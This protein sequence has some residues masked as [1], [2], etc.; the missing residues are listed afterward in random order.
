M[1]GKQKKG[2]AFPLQFTYKGVVSALHAS[3][4]GSKPLMV[5]LPKGGKKVYIFL[6]I[7][8]NRHKKRPLVWRAL[9]RLCIE[10]RCKGG[11]CF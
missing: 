6:M 7:Q 11:K 9:S 8:T 1:C 5:F 10:L 4:R 2:S 3:T